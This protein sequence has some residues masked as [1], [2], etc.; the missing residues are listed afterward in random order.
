MDCRLFPNYQWWSSPLYSESAR[1]G[2]HEVEDSSV[3]NYGVAIICRGSA[4]FAEHYYAGRTELDFF[5]FDEVSFSAA[6][7]QAMQRYVLGEIEMVKDGV[8]YKIFT[9][10]FPISDLFGRVNVFQREAMY[11]M[12]EVLRTQGDL[13]LCGDFN[14]SRHS[15][16][17]DNELW[18]MMAA[19]MRDNIPD[20]I[21][22]SIDAALH[23][24][25]RNGLDF[26]K[27]RILVDGVFSTPGYIVSDVQLISGV[28][29]HKAIRCIVQRSA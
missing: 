23:R 12:L 6:K 2:G 21:N 4:R 13:V 20:E 7:E 9:T 19:Q 25:G 15:A 27:L 1:V 10:H 28:S 5:E 17:P 24:S 8:P 11:S 26:E 14:T 16:A 18:D 29:D 22:S 3:C